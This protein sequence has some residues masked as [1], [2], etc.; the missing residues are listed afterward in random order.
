MSTYYIESPDGKYFSE[1]KKRRFIKLSGKEAFKFLNSPEYKGKYFYKL[2]E[3]SDEKDLILI[4]I[5][6]NKVKSIRKDVRHQQYVQQITQESEIKTIS[7]NEIIKVDSLNEDV[8][9]E[10]TIADNSI[11]IEELIIK[12]SE[13]EQLHNGLALLSE[14]ERE[15]IELLFFEKKHITEKEISISQGVSKQ[16]INKQKAKILIKL[17]K[18]L[19]N[20]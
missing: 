1:D 12:K 13:Y 15:L 6:Q 11:S 9:I 7:I 14:K 16:A 4:E 17:K 10:D 19:E 2:N 3:P 8:T 20:F 5:P 18:L